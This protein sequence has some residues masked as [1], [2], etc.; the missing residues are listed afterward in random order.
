MRYFFEPFSFFYPLFGNCSFRFTFLHFSI[1]RSF[2]IINF[3]TYG[4]MHF[5]FLSLLFFIQWNATDE[6]IFLSI[7]ILC[8]SASNYSSSVWQNDSKTFKVREHFFFLASA[9]FKPSFLAPPISVTP[10]Q[11]I[12]NL[13][14]IYSQSLINHTIVSQLVISFTFGKRNFKKSE[15]SKGI[16]I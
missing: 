5:F 13:S 3:V 2:L 7:K 15:G 6:D 12:Y 9:T 14:Q 1:H 4:F 11:D 16:K 8:Q 10:I